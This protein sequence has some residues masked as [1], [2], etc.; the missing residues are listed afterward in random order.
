MK[1]FKLLILPVLLLMIIS[2]GSNDFKQTDTGLTYKFHKENKGPKAVI[3]NIVK[4]EMAF[5]YPEDSV[6]MRNLGHDTSVYLSVQ[7]SEYEGDI[8]EGMRMLALGD[9]VTFKIDASQFFTVTMRSPMVPDFI[10]SGDSIY[11]DMMVLEIFNEEQFQEYQQKKR[12]EL[13]KDAEVAAHQEEGLREKYLLDNNITT[14]PEES[15]LII[16][17]EQKGNGP[18]P[19]P[20]QTVTVHYT[21]MLLDGSV[22]D[23]SVERGNPFRFTLGKG[24]VIRGW[25]EGFSKLN[26]GSKARLI[27]PSHLAYGDQARGAIITPFSTLIFDVEL[28][29][30]E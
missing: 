15:G 5:R 3:D 11:I 19:K 28:I 29:A 23:S 26:I 12:E 8:H 30:A 6:F 2:C 13:I 16:I 4:V 25:D 1:N 24:Q 10:A 14:Q 9:S 20:D 18:I 27:I 7:P 21:G 22:F 17:V